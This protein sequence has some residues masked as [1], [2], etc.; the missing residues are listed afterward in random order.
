MMSAKF[1]A[2]GISSM[3]IVSV[4][5]Y[6]WI[7]ILSKLK[8]RRREESNDV[9]RSFKTFELAIICDVLSQRVRSKFM[10]VDGLRVLER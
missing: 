5:R 1:V 7:S 2:D 9:T 6:K 8:S 4:K 10:E 3:K